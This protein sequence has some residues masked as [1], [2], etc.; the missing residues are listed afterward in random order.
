MGT[1]LKTDILNPSDDTKAAVNYLTA[2]SDILDANEAV[3]VTMKKIGVGGNDSYTKLLLHGDSLPFIDS[4]SS[5][6]SLTNSGVTLD[7]VNKVFGAGSMN[8]SSS[9]YLNAGTS[10]DWSLGSLWTIDLRVR[11]TSTNNDQIILST[12]N[13]G[14]A[15][16]LLLY[17]GKIRFGDY[18]LIELFSTNTLSVDTWYHIALTYDGTN[19]K[20]YIDGVLDSTHAV[21]SIWSTANNLFIGKSEAYAEYLIGQLDELRISK[22]TVRWTSAFTPPTSQYEDPENQYIHTVTTVTAPALSDEMFYRTSDYQFSAITRANSRKNAAYDMSSTS[23]AAAIDYAVNPATLYTATATAAI[24]GWTFSNFPTNFPFKLHVIG[25]FDITYGTDGTGST[26][27]QNGLKVFNVE[28]D[29]AN[30]QM[31]F[32]NEITA[33]GTAAGQTK[34]WNAT[35]SKW[36]N[37]T[38]TAGSDI[39]VTNAD[40]SITIASTGVAWTDYS[41]TSTI[42]GWTSLDTARIY[43]KK[44]GNLVF[45]NFYLSGTSDSTSITFTLPYTSKNVIEN[46]TNIPIRG[47]D[48]G[49]WLTTSSLLT[50]GVNT[51]TV[52]V[53]KDLSGATN[54]WTASGIKNVAGQFWYEAQ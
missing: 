7:T 32:E 49:S 45:V 15:W 52:V 6:Y 28:Y 11:T 25:D 18:D 1:E 40:G 12:R 42:V 16:A 9:N 30:Y 44:I 38:L 21:S 3:P 50:L 4:S 36:V 35:T 22:G 13:T 8:F 27:N 53:D 39:T 43:Y 20:M 37:A 5:G 19:I 33:I 26:A 46:L 54:Q 47:A 17:G 48:N 51:S 23:G 2:P 14:S 10:A 41:G 31:T 24:T 29:G 34:I